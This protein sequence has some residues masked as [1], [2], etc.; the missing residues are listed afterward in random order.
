MSLED[1]KGVHD[2]SCRRQSRGKRGQAKATGGLD[3]APYDLEISHR[4]VETDEDHHRYSRKKHL[5][6][7]LLSCHND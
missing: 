5:L 4:D 6:Q 7:R 2:L 1:N 3:E